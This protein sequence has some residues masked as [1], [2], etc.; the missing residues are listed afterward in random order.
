MIVSCRRT[1]A[2]EG[3]VLPVTHIIACV[4][5]PTSVELVEE[6]VNQQG[7]SLEWLMPNELEAGALVQV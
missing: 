1:S 3:A 5:Q 4:E 7:I 6:A 2:R